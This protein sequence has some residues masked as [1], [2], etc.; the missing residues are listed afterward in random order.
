MTTRRA[1]VGRQLVHRLGIPPFAPEITDR[2][3]L[4]RFADHA[5]EAAFETLFRRHGALVLAVAQR[6]LGCP[7]DAQDVCQAAFL[8][9]A[10]KA[11]SPR[12]QPSVANWLHR[13]AH[14]LAL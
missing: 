14:L 1:E 10:R 9:L 5:D 3:L 2:E 11:G 7:H 13:T 12:W 8:L 4:G 6:A